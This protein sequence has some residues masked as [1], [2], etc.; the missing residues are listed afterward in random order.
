MNTTQGIIFDIKRFAVHDGP[1]IRQTIFLKGCPLRCWWCH[2]PESQN[3]AIEKAYKSY[4]IEDQEFSEEI[5][6][7]RIVNVADVMRVIRKDILYFDGSGGGVTLSGGE[8]LHQPDFTCELL[9]ACR[10]EGI[11]TALDTCGYAEKDVF[12]KIAGM[13]DLL[14]Y[15]LKL[16]DDELHQNFTGVSNEIILSNLKLAI[17]L[18]TTIFIRIPLIPS[19][20]DTEKNITSIWEFLSELKGISEIDLLPFHDFAKSKYRR[21]EKAS[22]IDDIEVEPSSNIQEIKETFEILNIPVKI[23]G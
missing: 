8:P 13:S 2:N 23:G 7:G 9:K 3:P 6:I 12:M 4:K 17:G 20:T 11:H 14:L 10:A 18:G 15:D 21:Y 16:M 22:L 19:I 5:E 1:G